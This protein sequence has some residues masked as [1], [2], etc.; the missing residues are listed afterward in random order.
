MPSTQMFFVVTMFLLFAGCEHSVEN[1]YVEFPGTKFTQAVAYPLS[2]DQEQGEGIYLSRAHTTQLLNLFNNKSSFDDA[3]GHRCFQ[4]N[5]KI[6]FL[7]KSQRAI[8]D[9]EISFD[10]NQIKAF[11]TLAHQSFSMSGFDQMQ[12]LKKE[13]LK[14]E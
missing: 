10:C 6:T 2:F 1:A 14:R 7:T 13:F 4:P 11:P 12:R 3:L 9:L 8:A 5:L